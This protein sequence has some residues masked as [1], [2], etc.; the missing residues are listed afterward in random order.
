M[1]RILERELLSL[2]RENRTDPLRECSSVYG[3]LAYR[4]LA[5][6]EVVGAC[7]NVSNGTIGC[8]KCSP[9]LVDENDDAR[10]IEN[11]YVRGEAV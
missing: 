7:R 11:R 10:L 8:G 9:A 5:N 2:A 1:T 6:S 3:F 4:R